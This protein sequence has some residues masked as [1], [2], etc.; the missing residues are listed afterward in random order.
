MQHR[1]CV[2]FFFFCVCA[3]RFRELGPKSESNQLY[4]NVQ[5]M[6]GPML[7]AS[8]GKPDIQRPWDIRKMSAWMTNKTK[9]Q[10]RN[11]TE[12]MMLLN[13]K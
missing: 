10:R 3:R 12:L 1:F 4:A 11:L 7:D 6:P 9:L 13:P 8:L 2:F 5:A